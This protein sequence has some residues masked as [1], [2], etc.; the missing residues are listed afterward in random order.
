MIA[1][2]TVHTFRPEARRLPAHLARSLT[3]DHGVE[4]AAH[5]KFTVATDMPVF[6]VTRIRRSSAGV[7]PV[8]VNGYFIWSELCDT[9]FL[10]RCV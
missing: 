10:A 1:P 4:R 7:H 3:W 6:F 5:A 2:T 9:R 8:P